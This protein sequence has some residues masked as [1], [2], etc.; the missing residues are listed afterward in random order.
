MNEFI[1]DVGYLEPR[2][3]RALAEYLGPNATRAQSVGIRNAI[4][5]ERQYAD[6]S[7]YEAPNYKPAWERD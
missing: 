2:N 6:M 1:S 4:D 3:A 5:A 7:V